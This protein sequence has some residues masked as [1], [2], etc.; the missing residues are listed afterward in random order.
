MGGLDGGFVQGADPLHVQEWAQKTKR[1]PLADSSL[2][3]KNKLLVYLT[4]S[5]QLVAFLVEVF[6][7]A[8]MHQISLGLGSL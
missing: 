4:C 7:G 2:H 1:V 8:T 6:Q 3:K 5:W